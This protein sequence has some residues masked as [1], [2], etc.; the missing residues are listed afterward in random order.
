MYIVIVIIEIANK[1]L[2]QKFAFFLRDI[3]MCLLWLF[4]SPR[5][6]AQLL[7]AFL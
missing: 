4:F 1:H 3:S 2:L 7:R 6:N 5:M